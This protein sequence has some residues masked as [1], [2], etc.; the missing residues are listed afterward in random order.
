MTQIQM[1]VCNN[2]LLLN[3]GHSFE[4]G[5]FFTSILISHSLPFAFGHKCNW[6]MMT[7][8]VLTLCSYLFLFFASTLSLDFALWLTMSLK[9]SCFSD[10][11]GV[12]QINLDRH[13]TAAC[14]LLGSE[15]ESRCRKQPNKNFARWE[16]HKGTRYTETKCPVNC[17]F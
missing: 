10:S 11:L 4:K 2:N 3:R 13:S 5:F 17:F 16:A 12:T 8:P 14:P 1:I 9:R 7:L 6:F 15:S